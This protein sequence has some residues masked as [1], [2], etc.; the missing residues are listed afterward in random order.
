MKKCNI[1]LLNLK[2]KMHI[3][4]RIVTHRVKYIPILFLNSL[5]LTD[6]ETPPKK[7][8]SW[9]RLN[10]G[11]SQC[12]TLINELTQN[13]QRFPVHLNGLSLGQVP[14]QLL[15]LVHCVL[16]SQHSCQP[17]TRA[18]PCGQAFYGDASVS[19]RTWF[20]LVLKAALRVTWASI[21]PE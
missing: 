10:I 1:F 7:S 18:S 2:S 11:T 20:L 17:R 9:K 6:N 4:K 15:V 3:F 16:W 19:S 12:H 21:T 13:L 8:V 14:G 5:W